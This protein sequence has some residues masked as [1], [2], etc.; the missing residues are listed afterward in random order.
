MSAD[1]HLSGTSSP[2]LTQRMGRHVLVVILNRPENRNS[3]D[4]KAVE[5]LAEALARAESDASIRAVVL[6]GAGEDWFCA[7]LD[8]ETG[9]A[10]LTTVQRSDEAK[11][12]MRMHRKKP[13]IA[14]VRGGA[15]GK[16]LE[17]AMACDWLIAGDG[18]VFIKDGI[19]MSSTSAQARG[20]VSRI[21]PEIDVVAC[22]LKLAKTIADCPTFNIAAL[23]S[24]NCRS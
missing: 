19:P 16:G 17:L 22:A 3:L 10:I 4:S 8:A 23:D 2:V 20:I 5:A 24:A 12:R 21:V 7:G 15:L 6:T 9:A 14:A 11:S 18:A 13:W 1:A